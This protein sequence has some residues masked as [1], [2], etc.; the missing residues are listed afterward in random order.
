MAE[1]TVSLTVNGRPSAVQI[2]ESRTLLYL[3]REVLGLKGSK[4]GCGEGVCGAC[5]VLLDGQ[6]VN[7]CLVLAVQAEGKELYTIEGLGAEGNL[8]PLQKAFIE[9]GAVQC[10]YCTP[11]MI[12]S[13]KALLDK[14]SNPSEVE[15]RRGLSGNLCRCTGY[16]KIIDA[17]RL[18][19]K[20]DK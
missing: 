13:A 2:D 18:A 19:S 10:G 3:I 12:I 5:T 15:I 7:A 17:V 8:H 9:V 20:D 6:A 16:Q 14:N 11:G 4:E 1:T